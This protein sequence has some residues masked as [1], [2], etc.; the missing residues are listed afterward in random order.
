MIRF[1]RQLVFDGL[2]EWALRRADRSS[3]PIDPTRVEFAAVTVALLVQ[4]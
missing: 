2:I 3:A 1:L 4:P